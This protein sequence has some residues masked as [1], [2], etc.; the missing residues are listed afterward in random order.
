MR[1]RERRQRHRHT[2]THTYGDKKSVK[3]KSEID[4]RAL[5]DTRLR[6]FCVAATHVPYARVAYKDILCGII[7]LLSSL[8]LRTD[9][10]LVCWVRFDAIE[11]H[12]NSTIILSCIDVVSWRVCVKPWTFFFFFFFFLLNIPHN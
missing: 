4:Y 9:R 1:I 7:Y 10:W 11:L 6:S 8:R 2:Q 5:S 3:E 12:N